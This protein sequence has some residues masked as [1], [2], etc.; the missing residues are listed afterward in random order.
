[1]MNFPLRVFIIVGLV[2][3]AIGG[4]VWFNTQSMKGSIDQKE[5]KIEEEVKEHEE[6]VFET[7]QLTDLDDAHLAR[8]PWAPDGDQIYFHR[9]DESKNE[10]WSMNIDATEQVRNT[11]AGFL[12]SPDGTNI[13]H[14]VLEETSTFRCPYEYLRGHYRMTDQKSSDILAINV[15]NGSETN[16]SEVEVTD[17][18][19]EWSP[20]GKKILYSSSSGT[21]GFLKIWDMTK[22]ERMQ[23]LQDENFISGH[24][25]SP[26]GE[27]ILFLKEKRNPVISITENWEKERWRIEGDFEKADRRCAVID[28]GIKG[29][30]VWLMNADGSNPQLLFDLNA[31]EWFHFS[32]SESISWSPDGKKIMVTADF[33]S[34]E[35]SRQGIWAIDLEHNATPIL[36]ET[37]EGDC[38]NPITWDISS[39]RLFYPVAIGVGKVGEL[40]SLDIDG[41]NKRKLTENVNFSPQLTF[42][43]NG[44]W[45]VFKGNDRQLWIMSIDGTYRQKLTDNLLLPWSPSWNPSGKTLIFEN[46][47]NIWITEFKNL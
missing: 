31:K 28:G 6:L 29:S 16:I 9:S 33:C 5:G 12:R 24:W 45:L 43:P 4:V 14:T 18:D 40:W 42:H 38:L 39:V 37:I 47:G 36:L 35:N 3:V 34:V 2:V 26:S 25:M 20:D 8:F 22:S 11:N 32:S 21:S 1:M 7:K 46:D 19:A 17:Y 41:T 30:E 10:A 15:G 13:L 23:V 44:E 27:K